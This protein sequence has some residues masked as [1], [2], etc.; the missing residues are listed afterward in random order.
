MASQTR[1]R[2][3]LAG[4]SYTRK[5]QATLRCHDT[6]V[7]PPLSG[8][9]PGHIHRL[10]GRKPAGLRMAYHS[11]NVSSTRLPDLL[12]PATDKRMNGFD[13]AFL[14]NTPPPKGPVHASPPKTG[15]LTPRALQEAG[16]HRPRARAPQYWRAGKNWTNGQ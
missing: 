4:L 1:K 16:G 12:Y 14:L 8:D 13:V 10:G 7:S 6:T 11:S 2:W 3:Q 9:A 15:G 5:T